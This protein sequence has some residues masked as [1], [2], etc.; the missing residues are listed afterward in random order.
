MMF[1]RHNPL[2]GIV[3]LLAAVAKM[4]QKICS[5]GWLQKGCDQRRTKCFLNDGLIAQS[6]KTDAKLAEVYSS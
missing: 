6:E 2:N 3:G 4:E 1:K 5:S